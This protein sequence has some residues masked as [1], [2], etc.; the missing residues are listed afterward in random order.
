MPLVSIIMPTCD[1]PLL[2]QR[3]IRSVVRQSETNWELIVVDNNRASPPVDREQ[4]G[5]EVSGDTRIRIIRAPTANNAARARNAGL[6]V[7]VGEWVTYLDDDDMYHPQKLERQLA[8]ARE[9][10]SDVI[11]CG[12]CFHLAARKRVVQCRTVVWS[13]DE[14]ILAARWNTPL[15]MHRH[16]GRVRFDG[17]LSPGED[18]EFAHRLLILQGVSSVPVVPEPLVDIY[19][20]P[21]QRVNSNPKP[22]RATTA[23]ILALRPN[24]YSRQA[25]RRYVLQMLMAVEKLSRRPGRCAAFAIR[26]LVESRGADWRAALNAVMVSAGIWPGRWVS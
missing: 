12:G 13:G 20:Q 14:L 25:R 10:G 8:K 21:G 2:L 24:G 16:P 4:L 9:T 19:P 18:A 1:R 26:L 11:L 22:L 6:D 3:A 17:R 7:A 15:L 23:R 5:V